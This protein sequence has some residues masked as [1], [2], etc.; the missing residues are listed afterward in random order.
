MSC[1]RNLCESCHFC[2]RLR[3]GLCLWTPPDYTVHLGYNCG[4]RSVACFFQFTLE[5]QE[6]VIQG[7][8]G[9]F[10]SDTE[11]PSQ[12]TSA[13]TESSSEHQQHIGKI[14]VAFKCPLPPSRWW[15]PN[16]WSTTIPHTFSVLLS[17]KLTWTSN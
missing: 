17:R 1:L 11:N 15:Y 10:I 8:G 5:P 3:R 9:L 13:D 14:P 4:N 12:D 6:D 16:F 7:R 2:T